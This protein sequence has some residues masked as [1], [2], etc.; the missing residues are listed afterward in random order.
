MNGMAEMVADLVMKSLPEDIRSMLT[1]ENLQNLER[2]I[3]TKW[4]A[5]EGALTTIMQ[6]NAAIMGVVTQ[7]EQN[8]EDVI[9]RL[10]RIEANVGSTG[11]ANRGGGNRK[12]R[13]LPAPNGS[14]H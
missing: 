14:G 3:R 6:G 10:E 7:N 11:R 1:P 13:A 9:A 2:N 4:G 8:M 5:V 12:P